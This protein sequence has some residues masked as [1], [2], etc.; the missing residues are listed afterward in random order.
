MASDEDSHEQQQARRVAQHIVGVVARSRRARKSHIPIPSGRREGYAAGRRPPERCYTALEW[1]CAWPRFHGPSR[2]SL[3][4][5]EPRLATCFLSRARRLAICRFR[6]WRWR[7]ACR[8][9]TMKTTAVASTMASVT[10][11]GMRR[12]HWK[13]CVES[14]TAEL[15][16]SPVSVGAL[17]GRGRGL[18]RKRMPRSLSLRSLPRRCCETVSRARPLHSSNTYV[19][20]T[21]DGAAL[22]VV[23]VLDAPAAT[24][25]AEESE[26]INEEK[27]A[28]SASTASDASAAST[29]R[30][31]AAWLQTSTSERKLMAPLCSR[32]TAV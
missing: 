9:P 19:R 16:T 4:E 17:G 32:S 2:H 27:S 13:L 15:T 7:S 6:P 30:A 14:A 1:R 29:A 28:L 25:A 12:Y 24:T 18:T 11:S 20:W 10:P 8:I 21:V 5:E 3:A 22:V 23:G 26:T 31:Q